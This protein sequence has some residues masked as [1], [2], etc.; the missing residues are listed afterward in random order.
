MQDWQDRINS[1]NLE[2]QVTDIVARFKGGKPPMKIIALVIAF[3][4]LAWG[5]V[6]SFYEVG[7]EETGV[8][9]RFG[10]FNSFAA[11]GLHFKLPFGI[12]TVTWSRPG[13]SSRRSSVS[14]R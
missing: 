2:R 8:V 12:D 1:E 13:A 3:L 11:P 4:I 14:H 10:H 7:T 5:A 9:L 6:S